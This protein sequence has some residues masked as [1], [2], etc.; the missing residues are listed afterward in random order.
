[1]RKVSKVKW[2]Y[3]RSFFREHYNKEDVFQGKNWNRPLSSH[4]AIR[5]TNNEWDCSVTSRHIAQIGRGSCLNGAQ[6]PSNLIRSSIVSH[7]TTGFFQCAD[8]LKPSVLPAFPLFSTRHQRQKGTLCLWKTACCLSERVIRWARHWFKKPKALDDGAD[9]I[10]KLS[11][12]LF[13]FFGVL[14]FCLW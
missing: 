7:F 9:L 6:A 3:I 12:N 14:I 13:S 8:V 4:T 2:E 10:E 11:S 1:M 5:E